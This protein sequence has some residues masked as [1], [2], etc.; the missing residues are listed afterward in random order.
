MRGR[1]LFQHASLSKAVVQP[2]GYILNGGPLWNSPNYN[3][4]IDNVSV[5]GVT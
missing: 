3:G 1:S 2:I 4:T 5:D